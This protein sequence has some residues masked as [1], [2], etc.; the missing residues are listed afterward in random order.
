MSNEVEC[1]YLRLLDFVCKK[2]VL[3]N[4]FWVILIGE[5][6]IGFFED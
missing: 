6:L 5:D 4:L 3:K 2:Y 1:V